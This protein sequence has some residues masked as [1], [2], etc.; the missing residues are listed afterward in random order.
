M[1]IKKQLKCPR[2][3]GDLVIKREADGWFEECVL[4]GQRRDVSDLV[5]FNTVGQI[6][7]V[8]QIE[9]EPKPETNEAVIATK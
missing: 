7:L 5:T 3:N 6:K 4:C 8:D 9:I 2:C 1:I